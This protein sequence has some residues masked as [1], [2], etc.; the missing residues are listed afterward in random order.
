MKME[1]FTYTILYEQKKK[2][3]ARLNDKSLYGSKLRFSENTVE[4]L[5]VIVNKSYKKRLMKSF[6]SSI[7]WTKL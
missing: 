5:Y 7:V 3:A 6:Y 4:H 2:R 1:N